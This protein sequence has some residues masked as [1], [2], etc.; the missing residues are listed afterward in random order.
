M[1]SR[2]FESRPDVVEELHV[3]SPNSSLRGAKS[4]IAEI[5]R[6]HFS[7]EGTLEWFESV[8]MI[9]P[10][11]LAADVWVFSPSFD[12]VL[13][14]EHRW[15]GLLPPGGKVEPEKTSFEGARREQIKEN[16]LDLRLEDRPALAAVR[17]F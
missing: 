9:N 12:L 14:V 6:T 7:G 3:L 8:W 10:Q 5:P 15:R 2:T 13:L 4:A 1:G 11:P 17:S 16:G